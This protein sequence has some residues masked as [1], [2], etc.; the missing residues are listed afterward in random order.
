MNL[1]VGIDPSINSTGLCVLVYDD[2]DFVKEY[3]YI[4]KP[5]KLSK[6][7]DSAELKYIDKFE[8]LIYGK[9][10]SEDNH[11]EEIYKATNMM[12]IVSNIED[13]ISK[14]DHKF[15][16][17][18]KIYICIEG[19]SY[20]SSTRTKSIFDL[21]G[22][23]YLIREMVIRKSLSNPDKIR[24]VIGTPGE[25]KKFATG[26]GNANKDVIINCFKQIYPDFALPKL[27]DVADAYFMANYA[28][29]ISGSLE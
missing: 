27:D 16:A 22:L 2:N 10:T 25:I 7:E 5:N 29:S 20:G 12:N 26:N 13:A 8:Y 18:N 6:K 9:L 21:A 23:N 24:F 19:I 3:F 1:Y 14:V 17:Y 15:G 4:V 28:K 11:K